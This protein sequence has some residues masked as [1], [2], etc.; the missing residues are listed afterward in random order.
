MHDPLRPTFARLVRGHGPDEMAARVAAALAAPGG[1]L[2]HRRAGR[3]F[4]VWLPAEQRHTWSPWLHVDV[5]EVA[6]D[7][8]ASEL[9]GRF[10]PA[11]NLWTGVMLTYLA[12][13][14]LAIGGGLFGYAQWSVNESPWG[15]WLVGGAFACALLILASSRAGQALARGQMQAL[16]SAVE[17]ALDD[18]SHP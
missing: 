4:M 17:R 10:T 9:F 12:L 15:L 7:P 11:P 16:S 5:N 13:A 3:H 1:G 8:H 14:T 18:P 2:P 6:D